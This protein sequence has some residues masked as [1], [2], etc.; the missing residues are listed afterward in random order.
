M[1]PLPPPLTDAAIPELPGHYRGKVRENYDLPDGRR[2]LV[3]TDRLSAFDTILAS[4]PAK[5]QVL[6]ATARYWFDQTADICPNWVESYPDPNA[7]IGRRLT[8]LPVEIVIRGYL[9]GTTNT[10]LLT[11]YKAGARSLYGHTFPDGL[12]D[13]QPLPNPIITPTTKALAGAHDTPLTPGD[14]MANKLL[15]NDEWD[16]VSALAHQL[17]ARGTALAAR[18]G[19]MLADTKYEFGTDA[20]GRI[21]LADEIHTP[22]S[23]RYWRAST[24]QSR[25]EAGEPPDS[26]DK[27]F[28]RNWVA[29]RCDPYT[30]PIPPIPQ[31]LIEATAHVYIEAFATITGQH[32]TPAPPGEDILARIRHNLAPYFTPS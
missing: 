13:N 11:Q 10:S 9:A 3:A 6:T 16:Q 4:I 2:I 24:Y 12:R 8:I 18:Q 31:D 17:F 15:T 14:I 26:F 19:L 22:D 23:S 30:D 1:T 7:V 21:V 5:G 29:T 28:V 20:A 27:D 32:F 25:F